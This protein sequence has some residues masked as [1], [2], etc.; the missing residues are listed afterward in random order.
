MRAYQVRLL[1]SRG[2]VVSS[3]DVEW[4]DDA[5][6][7]EMMERLSGMFP[8]ELRAGDRLVARYEA[9]PV[10]TATGED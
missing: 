9:D 5:I 3:I 4:P 2:A 7:L 1:N 10:T 6:A 8:I